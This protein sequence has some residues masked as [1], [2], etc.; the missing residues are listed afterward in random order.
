[1]IPTDVL[2]YGFAT[3]IL[4]VIFFYFLAVPVKLF[5]KILHKTD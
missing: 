5:I 3:G 2:S 4:M 1:M